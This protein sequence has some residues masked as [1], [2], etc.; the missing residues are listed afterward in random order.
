MD[1]RVI[2]ALLAAMAH[3]AVGAPAGVQEREYQVP[4][5][6]DKFGR[7][8]YPA[9]GIMDTAEGSLELWVR[10]D[11]DPGVKLGNLFYSPAA[12]AVVAEPDGSNQRLYI[13]TRSVKDGRDMGYI[14]GKSASFISVTDPARF[15]WARAGEW[16]YLAFTWKLEGS[17]YALCMYQDGKLVNRETDTAS[18]VPAIG[19]D[20]ELSIGSAG[21][22]ASFIT[23]DE[24]RVS[25]A[26]RTP[27]VIRAAFASGA[28]FQWD[29]LTVLLDHLDGLSARGADGTAALTSANGVR[30]RV[31]GAAAVVAGRF[32]AAVRLHAID[33]VLPR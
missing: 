27:E 17:R 6:V 26:E 9:S 18:V 25:A 23:V 5:S 11:F 13:L 32:G 2:V 30:G 31:I 16:H 8:V 4:H 1:V 10:N 20:T 22:S 21:E 15:G 28:T 19:P 24:V 33:E 29:G 14:L 7:L 3:C 12:Y